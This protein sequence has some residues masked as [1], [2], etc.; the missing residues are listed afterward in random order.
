MS[1]AIHTAQEF[2]DVRSE[3]FAN[4]YKKPSLFDKLFR[5]AVYTRTAVA[6]NVIKEYGECTVLDIGSGPGVNSVTW[7]KN[8]NARHLLGIDF[9]ENMNEYARKTTKAEGVGDRAEFIEGDFLTYDFKGQK[10]DVSVAV[11]VLDYVKES[12]AFIKKMDQVS[13][14]AFV[15]SWPL[16]GLRMALRR[17][18]YTCPVYHYNEADVRRLHEGLNL[19]SL[20]II[21]TQGGLVSIA[22]K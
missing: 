11:G 1:K 9:A 17:R 13:A 6:L 19:K 5:K 15:V 8:T 3:L 22:R 14:K 16:N 10:Y 12:E 7:L 21:P 20:E 4:Y 2:W 18:R